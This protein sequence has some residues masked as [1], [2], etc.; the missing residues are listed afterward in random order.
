M[1]RIVLIFW[2]T[3]TLAGAAELPEVDKKAVELWQRGNEFQQ[4]KSLSRAKA[5][6][7]KALRISPRY[8]DALYNL[9]VVSEQLGEN[10]EAIDSYKKYLEIR[11]NDADVWNQLGVRYDEADKKAEAQAAYEK[12]LAIDP[13]FGLAHHNLGVMM[14]EQGKLDIAQKHFEQFVQLEEAAGRQTGDAYYSLGALLLQRG[15]VKDA[16]LLIQKALDTDPT[17]SYYNNAMGDVYLASSEKEL[18]LSAY[19]RALE[20]DA[21]YA[22]AYSGLGDAYR[23]AGDRE[24]AAEAYRKA[25][26]LRADYS[27]VHYKLGLL[28]EKTQPAEAIKSFEKYLT[29]A[30]NP[31]FQNEAKAK[32]E[33]L[34][35]AKTE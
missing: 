4:K 23:L 30:K 11:P 34:K 18:A 13:K 6:Y 24:K 21:K 32:I 17:T 10:T 25:L 26:E 35:Q 31:E 15:R 28:W 1:K 20:K 33:Q 22:P 14:K 5:E 29:S 8:L 16:K 7:Q 12:A 27:L 3:L 19:R 2:C 9:A